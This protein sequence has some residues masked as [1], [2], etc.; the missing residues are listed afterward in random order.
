MPNTR[1]LPLTLLNSLGLQCNVSKRNRALLW[2]SSFLIL[3]SLGFL[4][5][6]PFIGWAVRMAFKKG[7]IKFSDIHY[8]PL[9]FNSFLRR[10]RG[11]MA[12]ISITNI[13]SSYP[14]TVTVTSA[15]FDGHSAKELPKSAFV[16]PGRTGTVNFEVPGLPTDTPKTSSLTYSYRSPTFSGTQTNNTP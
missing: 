14:Y 13:D 15:T 7:V 6:K 4:L 8:A 3:A 10:S 11:C 16:L 5:Y 12:I 1:D 9:V 2:L